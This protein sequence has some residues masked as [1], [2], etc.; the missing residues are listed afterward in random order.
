[1]AADKA[2]DRVAVGKVVEGGLEE[3]IENVEDKAILA[4]ADSQ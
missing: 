2:A 1:M 3:D 4:F